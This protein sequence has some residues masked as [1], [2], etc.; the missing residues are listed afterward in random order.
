MKTGL[1]LAIL[2]VAALIFPATA[3]PSDLAQKVF[4][5]AQKDVGKKMWK[6]YGLPS[7]KL[8]CAAAL[9]NV[10]Q[11]GGVTDAHSATVIV[12]RNQLLYGKTKFKELVLRNHEGDGIDDAKLKS[13]ARP[14]DVV[15]AFMK[16]PPNPNGGPNAHCGIMGENGE[17]FTNDWNDGIWKGLNIHLMFD[18]YPYIRLIRLSG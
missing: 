3:A 6:G 18:Y 15:L 17:I 16:A 1:S 12:V 7:G 14:G 4:A 8:G 2:L 5:S 9:C 13:I 10:L 11:E